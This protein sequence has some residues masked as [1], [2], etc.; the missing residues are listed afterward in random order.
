MLNEAEA[1]NKYFTKLQGA[2]NPEISTAVY[3]LAFVEFNEEWNTK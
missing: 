1:E 2:T 3:F